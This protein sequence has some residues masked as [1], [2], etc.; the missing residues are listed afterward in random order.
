MN[1][2]K[3]DGKEFP[4]ALISLASK[5]FRRHTRSVAE[6]ITS[7]ENEKAEEARAATDINENSDDNGQETTD[8]VEKETTAQC[9]T[10]KKIKDETEHEDDIPGD[11]GRDE[12]GFEDDTPGDRVRDGHTDA[13]S[14]ATANTSL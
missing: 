14:I 4:E 12:I 3:D 11:R 5:E 1:S 8:N 10:D 2:K 9:K 6:I 13:P 7:N